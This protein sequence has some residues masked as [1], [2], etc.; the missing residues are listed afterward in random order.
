M[1][2][3]ILLTTIGPRGSGNPGIQLALYYLKA[4]FLKYSTKTKRADIKILSFSP[5]EKI[6]DVIKRTREAKPDIIGF[7]C[8]VWNILNII[9][10]AR[11]IKKDMPRVKIMMGGSEVSPRAHRLMKTH[12]FID[13]IVIGE[14]ERTFKEL[15]ECWLDSKTDIS[16]VDGL[17]CRKNSKII[18]TKE[19]AE[20]TNLDEIPSPYLEKV[21]D[22]KTLKNYAPYIP[23]ET[24]RGCPYRCHYCY[25]HKDFKKQNYFSLERV[26]KELKC[27]L[28]KEPKGV[29]L[30]DPTFNVNKKR[31]KDVL[32]IIIKYNKKSNLHVELKAEL[33]DEE[34]VGLLK[35][36]RTDFIEI[37]IQS[38]NKETLKLIN[39]HFEPK[40]FRKN[41]LFLNKKKVPYEIQLIDGLPA[42]NYETLKKA[43]DWLL[44]LKPRTIKIMRF[45]LLPGTYLRVNARRLGIKYNP[46]APYHSIESNTFPHKDLKKTEKLRAAMGSL[47]GSGLL[48]NSI[49]PLSKKL[50]ICFT[51]IFDE[52]NDWA[53]KEGITL[54]ANEDNEK[55]DRVKRAMAR[56]RISKRTDSAVDFVKYLCRRYKKPNVAAELSEPMRRD[57]EVF[58]KKQGITKEKQ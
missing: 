38:T 15:L 54:R 40:S 52:W 27:L 35:K 56:L 36:A 2:T 7:S 19:R 29:Y 55:D 4:Y 5:Q 53:K 39:R 49:Y 22:E 16:H 58:L 21:V 24:M 28:G 41:I 33:L 45:M 46:K 18:L 50:G 31:D 47:Y 11:A 42:D 57:G 13:A 9:K 1:K 44:T 6:E 8:Y 34:M 20:I 30:M 25:Y 48:R 17:A 51:E 3:K 26:E 10:V 37:G 23:T 12:S 14:G 32:R 43:V